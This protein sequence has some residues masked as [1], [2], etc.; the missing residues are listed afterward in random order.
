MER[1][2]STSHTSD[3]RGSSSRQASGRARPRGTGDGPLRAA[4]GLGRLMGSNIVPDPLRPRDATPG[5]RGTFFAIPD[6]IGVEL[7]GP[8]SPEEWKAEDDERKLALAPRDD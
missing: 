2:R 5:G 6:V 4:D 8:L 1:R 3:R 7:P